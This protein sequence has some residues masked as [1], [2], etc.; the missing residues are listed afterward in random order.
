MDF[1]IPANHK[2]KM[3]EIEMIDKYLDLARELKK[4]AVKHEGNGDANHSWGVKNSPQRLGKVT[5]GIGNQNQNHT[6]HSIV[7]ISEDT[8]KF[9]SPEETCC[10]SDSSE[11]LPANAVWKTHKWMNKI[12]YSLW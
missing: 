9:W 7:E 1:A 2:V 4:K 12:V 6:D 5:V 10:H 8:G 3:K 11:S